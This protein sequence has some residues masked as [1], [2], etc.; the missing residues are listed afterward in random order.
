MRKS[1]QEKINQAVDLLID[2]DTDLASFF[3]KDG[4][5]KELTKNLFEK[6]LKAGWM[7]VVNASYRWYCLS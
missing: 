5:L 4:M 7:Q 2:K 1:N 3:A 6:A